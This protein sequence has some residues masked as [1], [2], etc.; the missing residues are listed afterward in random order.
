MNYNLKS[1]MQYIDYTEDTWHA[2]RNKGIGGS[3]VA[4]ILGES[5]YA[6]PLSIYKAKVDGIVKDLS[7]NVYIRKGN[8]LEGYVR[9]MH[10]VPYFKEL[11]Y[12]VLHPQHILVNPDYPWIRANLDG[13]AIPCENEFGFRESP[14]NNIVIEIKWVSEWAEDSWGEDLYDGVPKH[15]YMQVQTYLA[16]TE[17]KKAVLFALFDRNWEVKT[18][19]IRRNE[20]VIRRILT[21][22]KKFY[23]R[24][25]CMKIQP[26]ITPSIDTEELTAVVKTDVTEP[27]IEDAELNVLIAEYLE[28]GSKATEAAKNM[29]RLKD[30]IIKKHL[31]GKCCKDH[32]FKVKLSACKTTRF[33]TTKL[34]EDN[35][36]LYKQYLKDSEYTRFSVK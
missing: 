13:L 7:D 15:Y 3:D 17:A 5:K 8:A 19:E 34:K 25:M 9:N 6:S 12:E 26:M 2:E 14:Q 36:T 29:T 30:E 22:T 32:I 35:P 21:E 20:G 4:A 11:G 27:L 33:D 10:C 28:A 16:V 31:E 24:N 23:D 1:D 18:F